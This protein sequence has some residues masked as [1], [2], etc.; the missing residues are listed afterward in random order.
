MIEKQVVDMQTFALPEI[1]PRSTGKT[2]LAILLTDDNI[3]FLKCYFDKSY[4][5]W[6]T[7]ETITEVEEYQSGDVLFLY[8]IGMVTY[9]PVS[10]FLEECDE[11][12]IEYVFT[13]L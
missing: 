6:T 13:S 8:H 9:T 7:Y 10:S 4:Y 2:R 5:R 12:A 11:K 3:D 1:N